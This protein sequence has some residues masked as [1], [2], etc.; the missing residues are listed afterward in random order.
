M[1]I[2]ESFVGVKEHGRNRGTVIDKIVLHGNGIKGQPYCAYFVHFCLDS[3]KVKL[4]N[5]HSGLATQYIINKSIK[6]GD[7]LAGT[8][9]VEPG[10]IIIWRRGI[11]KYG[12]IGF[13]YSWDRESGFVVEA[14]TTQKG[15]EGIWL[16]KEIIQPLNYFRIIAFTPVTY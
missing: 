1:V 5:V 6:A 4:P 3:A 15:I 7:V 2:A 13:V 14:N 16:K 11:T 10:A 8:K 9:Q 12:H